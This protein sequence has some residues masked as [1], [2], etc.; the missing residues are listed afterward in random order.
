MR[1]SDEESKSV[2]G[3]PYQLSL[4]QSFLSQSSLCQSRLVMFVFQG[5]SLENLSVGSPS[6]MVFDLL[7]EE[8]E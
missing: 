3:F 8:E 4:S 2:N 6:W 5:K 1:K 7:L